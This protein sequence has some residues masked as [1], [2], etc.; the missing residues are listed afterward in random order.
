LQLPFSLSVQS[1]LF[2]VLT[3]LEEVDIYG[4]H[5]AVVFLVIT[6]EPGKKGRPPQK[7]C[8]PVLRLPFVGGFL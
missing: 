7:A 8:R 2:L 5:V 6:L 1:A 3:S 4:A